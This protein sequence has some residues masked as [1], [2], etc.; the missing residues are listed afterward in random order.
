MT[1][2]L[3]LHSGTALGRPFWAVWT[4]ATVSGIGD[5]LLLVALPLLA[6]AVTRDPRA[7]AGV[8]AAQRLPWLLGVVGGAI[9]DRTDRRRLVVLV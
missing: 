1:V 2:N 9:A 8:A 4:A 5:G 6:A 7:V 3:K